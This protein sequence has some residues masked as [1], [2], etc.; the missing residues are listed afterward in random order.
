MAVLTLVT[1]DAME[2]AT[3]EIAE[4]TV[5]VIVVGTA[6]VLEA[7]VEGTVAMEAIVEVIEDAVDPETDVEEGELVYH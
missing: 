1:E 5:A 3:E 4:T 2:V 7:I 6:E